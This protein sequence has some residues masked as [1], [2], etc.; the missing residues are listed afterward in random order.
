MIMI[1]WLKN[2]FKR[3]PK[4]KQLDLFSHL[5]P[6]VETKEQ[7]MEKVVEKQYTK[8]QI[9]DIIT[10]VANEY[11]LD[12]VLLSSMAFMESSLNPYAKATTSSATGLFQFINT[13]WMALIRLYGKECGVNVGMLK[14]EELKD[15]RFDPKLSA[16]MMCRLLKENYNYMV[17]RLQVG[18]IRR[19]D[20]TCLYLAH[21]MGAPKATKL[22]NM[23]SNKDRTLCHEVFPNEAKANKNIFF[24][25]QGKARRATDI[26]SFLKAKLQKATAEVYNDTKGLVD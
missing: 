1:Q 25:K 10:S 19:I 16:H 2:L 8:K 13:T 14:D 18:E 5:D 26:Y 6:V 12:P 24:D 20:N 21:F 4:E 9:V 3:K 23:Y 15:L 22:L 11:G 17:T 7:V